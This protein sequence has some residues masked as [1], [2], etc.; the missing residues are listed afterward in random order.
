MTSTAP[1][2]EQILLQDPFPAYT[3]YIIYM[4][5]CSARI[6]EWVIGIYNSTYTLHTCSAYRFID[7]INQLNINVKL[8]STQEFRIISIY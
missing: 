6:H 7:V 1:P 4:I 3:L 5:L 8:R 2:D